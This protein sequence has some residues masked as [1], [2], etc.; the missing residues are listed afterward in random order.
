[1]VSQATANRYDLLI[2]SSTYYVIYPVDDPNHIVASGGWWPRRTI[3]TDKG[4]KTAEDET[5]DPEETPAWIRGVYVHPE[6]ARRG[7]G[8]R[9]VRECEAA[10]SRFMP[11]T[12]Y[13]LGSTMNAIP[14]YKACGYRVVEKHEVGV[15]DGE[16]LEV[17]MMEKKK[18]ATSV[19][20]DDF[21]RDVVLL[22]VDIR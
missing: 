19:E 18:G 20:V 7:L 14:L 1:M 11:F 17:T 15:R 12:T 2:A 8:F 9:I 3:Y 6:Y 13:A 21:N 16:R 4:S 5:F 22:R 10:A